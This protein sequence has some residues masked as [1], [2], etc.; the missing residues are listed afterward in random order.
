MTRAN[1]YIVEDL[2]GSTADEYKKT[3]V[4]EFGHALGFFGHA[5]S[6]SAVMYHKGHSNY[7]LQGLEKNHLMQVYE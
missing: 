7:Q 5:S 3:C 2:N 4:H 6:T 1:I